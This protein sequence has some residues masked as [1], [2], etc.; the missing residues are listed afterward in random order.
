LHEISHRG[1]KCGHITGFTVKIKILQ[2]QDG[3]GRHI[4]NHTF[5]HKSAIFAYIFTKFANGVSQDDF[6]S[7]FMGCK[8]QKSN[9]AAA[10]I[11]KLI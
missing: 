4:E 7:K 5:G 6:P 10:A 2:I 9:M 1:R 8:N 11:M 3:G